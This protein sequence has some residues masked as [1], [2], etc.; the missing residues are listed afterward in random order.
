M[1]KLLARFLPPISVVLRGRLFVR[2]RRLAMIKESRLVKT[3][4]I[5]LCM[6]LASMMMLAA[7]SNLMTL[8]VCYPRSKLV[9]PP[10][11]ANGNTSDR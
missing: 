9:L 8:S 1:I 3:R 11:D 5:I 4:V 10:I 6:S 7:C 2:L